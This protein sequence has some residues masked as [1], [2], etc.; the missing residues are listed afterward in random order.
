MNKTG[1]ARPRSR[2]PANAAQTHQMPIPDVLGNSTKANI[3]N[4]RLASGGAASIS[5]VLEN[6][7][8][9]MGDGNASLN[10][11]EHSIHES[12]FKGDARTMPVMCHNCGTFCSQGL[13]LGGPSGSQQLCP[14][15]SIYP[16][17][18]KAHRPK[19]TLAD[20]N[21]LVSIR[22]NCSLANLARAENDIALAMRAAL[23][24]SNQAA[25]SQLRPIPGMTSDDSVRVAPMNAV[26]NSVPLHAQAQ[27]QTQTHT[28]RRNK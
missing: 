16:E 21:R 13:R 18:H 9:V 22:Q 7:S 12:R 1:N 5:N 20:P 26:V 25:A 23:L 3:S 28:Q 8:N 11:L 4:M 17:R 2:M 10:A 24:N 14:T 19:N 27:S 6:P 15:C